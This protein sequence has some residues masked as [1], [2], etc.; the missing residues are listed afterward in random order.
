MV[1]PEPIAMGPYMGLVASSVSDSRHSRLDLR[2]NAL[3]VQQVAQLAR[4]VHLA[5]DVAAADELALDVE[6]RNGRPLTEVLDALAQR[7]VGQD[8]DALELD[9]ELAQH[10]HDRGR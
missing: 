4:A 3:G 2:V 1:L 5:H 8:V 7:R 6:L 9:A 10:L